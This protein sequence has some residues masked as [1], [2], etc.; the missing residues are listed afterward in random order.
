MVHP[1][2]KKKEAMGLTHGLYSS[3]DSWAACPG[4]PNPLLNSLRRKSE[5]GQT[6]S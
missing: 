5:G 4:L 3:G 2:V 1:F 6:R